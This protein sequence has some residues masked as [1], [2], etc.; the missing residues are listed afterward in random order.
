MENISLSLSLSLRGDQSTLEGDKPSTRKGETLHHNRRTQMLSV[1]SQIASNWA[2]RL[3]RETKSDY[4]LDR[5]KDFL[6][7]L[8]T[9]PAEVVIVRT[10]RV[11]LRP[12][13]IDMQIQHTNRDHDQTRSTRSPWKKKKRKEEE[14]FLNAS[15]LLACLPAHLRVHHQWKKGGG[16][17]NPA[18]HSVSPGSFAGHVREDDKSAVE[19]H[20]FRTPDDHSKLDVQDSGVQTG[21]KALFPEIFQLGH[22]DCPGTPV[23]Y[24]RAECVTL[25]SRFF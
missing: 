7:K 22:A 2:K 4:Q 5:C 24:D 20:S 6:V 21:K 8:S 18:M 13:Q 25:T 9:R 3:K 16:A 1:I 11:A 14:H 10:H 19:W 12:T 17:A 15:S 23:R